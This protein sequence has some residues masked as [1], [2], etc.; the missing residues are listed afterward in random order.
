MT[1][2][3]MVSYDFK[4]YRPCV[5]LSKAPTKLCTI[6]ISVQEIFRL[7]SHAHSIQLSCHHQWSGRVK[8]QSWAQVVRSPSRSLVNPAERDFHVR[9]CSHSKCINGLGAGLD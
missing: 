9:L 3:R 7:S 8:Q 1:F 2:T 6:S 5:E 4:P